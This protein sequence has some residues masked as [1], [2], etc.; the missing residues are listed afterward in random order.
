MRYIKLAL[1]SL[2]T[3]YAAMYL[4]KA[5]QSNIQRHKDK[6]HGVTIIEVDDE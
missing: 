5:S 1:F 2:F 4:I 6:L 3:A